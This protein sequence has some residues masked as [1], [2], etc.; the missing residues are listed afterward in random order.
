MK[1]ISFEYD[2]ERRTAPPW[3]LGPGW[4]PPGASNDLEQ[5]G[6]KVGELASTTPARAEVMERLEVHRQYLAKFIP[7]QV[8]GKKVEALTDDDIE[9][10]ITEDDKRQMAEF[11]PLRGDYQ[12]MSVEARERHGQQV[13]MDIPHKFPALQKKRKFDDISKDVDNFTTNPGFD[14]LVDTFGNSKALRKAQ[15]RKTEKANR[16]AAKEKRL[17]QHKDKAA[18][19]SQQSQTTGKRQRQP[20]DATDSIRKRRRGDRS[21]S[22]SSSGMREHSESD[23]GSV[24]PSNNTHSMQLRNWSGPSKGDKGELYSIPH[25]SK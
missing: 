3:P 20:Y 8:S 25:Q 18:N 2:G 4:R 10:L 17:L 24:Y 23:T 7:H 13:L 11:L 9:L 15:E 1:C 5:E 21:E 16:K 12:S 6:E 14:E 22:V 19:G